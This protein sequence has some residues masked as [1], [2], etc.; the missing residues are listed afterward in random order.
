MKIMLHGG[1][2][3]GTVIDSDHCCNGDDKSCPIHGRNFHHSSSEEAAK[4]LGIEI[5][6]HDYHIPSGEFVGERRFPCR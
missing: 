2:Y 1:P 4:V 6:E 3:D 5:T